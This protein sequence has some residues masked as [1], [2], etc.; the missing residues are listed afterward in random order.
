MQTQKIFN[1]R[2]RVD[3]VLGT[4]GM[5]LVYCGTDTLLRR[6]VAIKVLRD[7][8][9][10][11]EDFVKR[12]SYEAQSAAKLSHPNIVNVY[13]FG[14]ENDA[15]Y[16]VM[17]LV[18]GATLGELM[19]D[20]HVLPELTAVDYAIQIASGLAYAHRQGLLHRDVKPANILVTKDDVVKLSDFGIAR[21]VSEH[22]LGVTQP[23]MVMGSVAYISPEQAQ[24][25][26][27]DERSDLYSV[28]VVLYQ[29]LT[30]ALPFTGDTPVAVA[31]KHV[32]EPAPAI[33][34]KATGVSPAIAAIVARLLRKDPA[35]RFA[36]ATE[37][38]SALRDARERPNVAHDGFADAPTSRIPTV[39]PPPRRS[40]APDAT[41]VDVAHE[42]RHGVDPRWIVMPLLLVVAIAIGFFALRGAPVFAPADAIAV[43][44][45]VNASGSVAAERLDALGLHAQTSEEPSGTVRQGYVVRQDPPAGAKL[46][47]DAAV[48]LVISSG[49]PRV[50]VPDV[51]GYSAADA[52]RAL[53][54]AKLKSKIA[55]QVYSASIPAGQVIDLNPGVGSSV[56]ESSVIALTVSKGVQPVNVPSIVSLKVPE[57]RRRLAALGLTLTVGQQ[58][59]SDAVPQDEIASQDPAAGT[60]VAPK[61]AVSV[62]VST[63]PQAVP[64]PNVVGSDPDTAQQTLRSAGFTSSVTYNVDASNATQ[65]V[66]AQ[67]PDS[68]ASAKKG[69]T[70]TIFVSVPGTVPDVTGMTLDAAR[71]VLAA[72][73]YQIGSTAYTSD[74]TNPGGQIE[75][76]QVVRTE[77]EAGQPLTP[78]ESVNI[79]VMRSGDSQ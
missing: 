41:A 5:A 19:R 2:Y 61:T 64:V 26:E 50:Q 45:L 44:D 32:S 31:L 56:R 17:E 75:D 10:E 16:I 22:T 62:I 55:A 57:A 51:K 54:Q 71:K 72:A 48:A 43:P 20:E 68:G 77:P 35:E 59:E 52:Q 24:G 65:K 21:A 73:G 30:G 49:P 60:T 23:G 36:S 58:T 70:V 67:R 14:R 46:A 7:Q 12:F 47:K 34:P 4:G 3:G 1:N 74:E 28:G 6:R 33:D 11:D 53:Q 79:T 18:D 66:S 39:P 78:G 15:Y 76:G 40:A 13:D 42:E 27:I 9:A 8:Y 63:G 37:L 29:M 69:S 25:H 38:A